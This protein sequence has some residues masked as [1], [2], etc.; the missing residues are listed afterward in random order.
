MP[1]YENVWL[2]TLQPTL[3]HLTT[4]FIMYMSEFRGVVLIFSSYIVD[5]QPS[6][7][8]TVCDPKMRR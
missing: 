2:Q 3:N 1:N 7:S 6:C 8:D 4:H 5:A